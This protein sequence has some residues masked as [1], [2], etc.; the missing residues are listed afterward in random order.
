MIPRFT[1]AMAAALMAGTAF[2]STAQAASPLQDTG[3]G[4]PLSIVKSIEKVDVGRQSTTV[5][6]RDAEPMTINYEGLIGEGGDMRMLGYGAGAALLLGLLGL[7]GSLVRTMR[8]ITG[9]FRRPSPT[10]H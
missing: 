7:L 8:M 3:L 4:D 6:L 5:K 9:I 2:A 10:R 1:L